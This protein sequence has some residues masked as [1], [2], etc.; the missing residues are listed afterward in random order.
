MEFIY[1]WFNEH[2]PLIPSFIQT[3]H[4]K[5]LDWL[6]ALLLLPFLCYWIASKLSTYGKWATWIKEPMLSLLVKNQHTSKKYPILLFLFLCIS[7]IALLGPS[8]NTQ[9]TSLQKSKTP[10]FIVLDL[11][12]S[13]LS[14]DVPPSRLEVAK[15]RI[16]DMLRQQKDGLISLTVYSGSAHIVTPLTEDIE[17]TLFQ[18]PKLNPE[19]M[20]IYGSNPV[21]AF[22]LITQVI[23]QLGNPAG[24]IIWI[25]DEATQQD[26]S[27]AKALAEA[28][29]QELVMIAIGTEE[30][31]IIPLSNGPLYAKN[32]SLAISKTPLTTMQLSA[33]QNGIK[34]YLS[35]QLDSSI[36]SKLSTQFEH[37]KQQQLKQQ[38]HL[39]QWHDLGYWLNIPL[40]LLLI[41]LMRSNIL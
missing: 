20:P 18:L 3:L 26:I 37:Q 11:S 22:E 31:A 8:Q 9:Q 19:I 12:L 6:W 40:L 14:E 33:V 21:Q 1:T 35:D 13:M 29:S 34:Y 15:Y 17:T 36:L 4:W 7:I 25:T 5:R 10:L 24:R 27:Q 30:G 16:T 38:Q 41:F 23:A 39:K 32:N 2:L 28:H